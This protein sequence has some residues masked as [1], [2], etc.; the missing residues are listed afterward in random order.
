MNIIFNAI[1]FY[2]S[3]IISF[4]RAVR[5]STVQTP[6]A[7]NDFLNILNDNL[8]IKAMQDFQEMQEMKNTQSSIKQV[9]L[10]FYKKLILYLVNR[11][12]VIFLTIYL[13]CI[14]FDAM[15]HSLFYFNS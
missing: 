12:V 4:H 5:G 2:Y 8:R 9:R 13:Y 1:L 3:D 15:G 11:I 6:E 7:V 10:F 14:G